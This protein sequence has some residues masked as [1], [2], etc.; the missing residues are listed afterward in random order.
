MYLLRA[1][2][3]NR[4]DSFMVSGL[5]ILYESD[6]LLSMDFPKNLQIPAERRVKYC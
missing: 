2:I 6:V 4:P 3:Q 1:L 5:F